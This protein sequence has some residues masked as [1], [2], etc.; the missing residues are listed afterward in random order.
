VYVGS[1]NDSAYD[2]DRRWFSEVLDFTR[3]V[4]EL[5]A[6]G[7]KL[8]VNNNG[9]VGQDTTLSLPYSGI[10]PVGGNVRVVF[11]VKTNRA[12]ADGVVSTTGTG[13]TK[14]GAAVIDDVQV[15]GGATY[16]FESAG[17]VTARSLIPDLAADGGA[18]ATT[19]RP[20]Q[21]YIHVENVANLL[22]EDLCG[23]VGSPTRLCNLAGN[24]IV[25]G[26]M[27]DGDEFSHEGRQC[28]ESPTIN[29]AVRTAAPG[30]KNDQGIDQ[31]A[32]ARPNL[33]LD[34]DFYSGFMGLDQSVFWTYGARF[35]GPTAVEP[36]STNLACWSPWQFYPIPLIQPDPF[37]LRAGQGSP[38]ELGPIGIPAG[39]IDSAKVV[40]G[41]LTQFY[42]FG[43]TKLG[44]TRGT[45]YDNVRLGLV[46]TGAPPLVQQ[47]WNKFQDQFPVNETVVPG[48]NAGFDTTTAYVRS[49]LNIV[50]PING[51]G[52][53]AGDTVLAEAPFSGDGV[54]TGVRMDLIFRIDPGPGNY[55]V[56]GDRTSPLVEKDPAH[57]FWSAYEADNGAFGTGGN[58]LSG[59][60]HAGGVWNKDL[61]NSCR[62]DSAELNLWPVV[63][64]S[65][66]GPASP[67]WMGT[68]HE[69]DPKFATL[70]IAHHLCFL[71]DPNG[72]QSVGNITCSGAAPAPY[73]TGAA[74]GPP[75]TM[76]LEGTKIIP[77]GYLSPGAHVEYFI[78]KSTLDAP[79]TTLLLFDT[80]LV[81]PQAPTTNFDLDEERWSSFNVLPDLWKSTR[82]GGGG[83]ACLLLVDAADRRGA[84]PAYRGAADTLGY[85]KNNGAAQGWHVVDPGPTNAAMTTGD[86]PNN[87]AGFV[88]ANL[89]QYGLNYDHYDVRGA[90]GLQCG[91]M[92]ARLA[93]VQ[94]PG[95]SDPRR[96][97]R[98]G[99]S[100][101][102]LGTFYTAILH[103]A[104]DLDMG[105][106]EDRLESQGQAD[107]LA[108]YD[109][110]LNGATA[111]NPRRV[112]LSGDGIAE[113]GAVGD[114]TP[115]L[116]TFLR[117][118]FG[119]G[120]T[121]QNYKAVT[122]SQLSTLGLLPVASWAHPGRVYGIDNLCTTSA[123]ILA[124]QVGTD[125]ATEAAQ[126]Q[127][128]PGP[129]PW[130]ASVYRPR[131]PGV[132]E[133]GTLLDG[134]QLGHLLADYASIGDIATPRSSDA[135][136]LGWFDDVVEN[137][138]FLCAR[139]GPI[140]GVG[141]LPGTGG[142]QFA[143]AN[144][145]AYP[146]PA[147]VAHPVTLR[148]TLAHAQ[149]VTVRI[150]TVAGREVAHL[151]RA[152]TAGENVVV[153]DGALA[154]GARA[155]PGVYFYSLTG[156]GLARDA[157]RPAR[158]V[159]L[160][161]R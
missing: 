20:P 6:Y 82:F 72:P 37:C 87:P 40:L 46:R 116:A 124:V 125:G 158:M 110:F 70:G 105:T 15:N 123:D 95:N 111:I 57:P 137:Q 60:G 101:L 90:E 102:M 86:G 34:F 79:F 109:T 108:L 58:G 80:T 154:N 139:K 92:G 10:V 106:I 26:D 1:P 73:A 131:N 67:E 156:D 100:Q 8:P 66:G 147:R 91:H 71:I 145:G 7:D 99:P 103:H 119:V 152:A 93:S 49:G 39:A 138:L 47:V 134:F 44:L 153:W 112:W 17:S 22:Y 54:S 149:A 142:V 48:D 30:T 31:A 23:A 159:L 45:Y 2:T 41:S 126:Y 33:L 161:A 50:Q 118:D 127:N 94:A 25:A 81:T 88:A 24:V 3:P 104:G 85:G 69:L 18:W 157:L 98:S 62:M 140:V 160:S 68:I 5:F 65:I 56:K 78:R 77:D 89:G 29:L 146:N 36:I 52:Y 136:R 133:Y 16:G 135:A 76:T 38:L 151:V 121:N 55:T 129:G 141:D 21:A 144:L 9:Q 63:S 42:R 12:R 19:G 150:Y 128:F 115:N 122:G 64:R 107:D 120:L 11:R 51:P 13:N 43:G 32:A 155:T 27:D 61:W 14:E 35:F 117:N 53:V 83:L 114:F 97:D 113:E 96:T 74:G 4:E 28:M 132:R 148:F 59:P 84:D 143:N 75:A 130:T